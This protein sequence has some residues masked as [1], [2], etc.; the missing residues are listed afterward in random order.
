MMMFKIKNN[1]NNLLLFKFYIFHSFNIFLLGNSNV[2]GYVRIIAGTFNGTK[3]P[4]K[5]HTPV[6]VSS[7]L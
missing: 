3:G 4:A 6:Q 2:E 7:I 1:V 5:T